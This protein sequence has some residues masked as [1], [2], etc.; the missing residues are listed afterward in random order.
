MGFLS[1]FADLFSK[2]AN[3]VPVELIIVG[4]G[5]IGEEYEFTRHNVGFRVADALIERVENRK[6]FRIAEADCVYGILESKNILI[7]KPRTLMNRSGLAVDV[8]S[9]KFNLKPS[10]V[11]VL[12]D[13]FNIPLG[14]IRARKGGSH[15]CH[16]GLK[17]INAYIGSDF[18]RIRIGIGPLPEGI[19]ILQFVLGR[20]SRMRRKC[21]AG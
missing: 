6:N 19:D 12:V 5:N 7:A 17:S 9:R 4:L 13:D 21:S 2:S 11:M 15:G 14:T 18:P 20:F 10:S 1:F 8:L 16:N 3:S